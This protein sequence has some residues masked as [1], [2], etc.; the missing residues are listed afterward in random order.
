L[1]VCVFFFNWIHCCLVCTIWKQSNTNIA[2]GNY[3][4][5][6]LNICPRPPH[7][8]QIYKEALQNFCVTNKCNGGSKEQCFWLKRMVTKKKCETNQNVTKVG[9]IIK[10]VYYTCIMHTL[11]VC[12]SEI[13]YSILTLA[14]IQDRFVPR[15]G[16]YQKSR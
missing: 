10:G 5:Q 3:T 13:F 11:A 9:V 12:N 1:C 6:N 2:E 4:L 16:M 8:S 14:Y 15:R 7:Y